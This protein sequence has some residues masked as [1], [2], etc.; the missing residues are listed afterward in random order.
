MVQDGP[1]GHIRRGGHSQDSGHVLQGVA[2]VSQISVG[3]G[4]V[5]ELI[6][7]RIQMEDTEARP[8]ECNPRTVALLPEALGHKVN[9]L[10]ILPWGQ[11]CAWRAVV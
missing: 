4:R 6:L 1:G 5:A 11:R 7:A 9:L 2:T 10:S 3:L 8:V